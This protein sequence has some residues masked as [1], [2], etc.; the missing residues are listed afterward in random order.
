[1][2]NTK[3]AIFILTFILIILK[4]SRKTTSWTIFTTKNDA[5]KTWK[6]APKPTTLSSSKTDGRTIFNRIFTI[7]TLPINPIKM[8]LKSSTFISE[9]IVLRCEF[10]RKFRWFECFYILRGVKNQFK[11]T[12]SSAFSWTRIIKFDGYIL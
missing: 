7:R 1:M 8:I 4:F 11:L 3:L 2:W 5:P 12:F 9:F 10:P 6:F